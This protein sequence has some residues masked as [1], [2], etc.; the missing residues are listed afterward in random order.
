MILLT[1][2]EDIPCFNAIDLELESAHKSN[3]IVESIDQD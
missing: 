3:D 1:V 2:P